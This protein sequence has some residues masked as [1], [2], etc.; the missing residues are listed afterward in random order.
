[1]AEDGDLEAVMGTSALDEID[2]FDR[3]QLATV[4]QVCRASH[5]LSDAGRKLFGAS[6]EKKASNNDADR[7]RKYLS[8]FGLDWDLVRAD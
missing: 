1:M 2:L 7:R 3:G 5:S 4:I 6:R 8:R